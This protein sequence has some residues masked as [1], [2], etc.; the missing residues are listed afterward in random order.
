M[1]AGLALSLRSK[2]QWCDEVL[3]RCGLN[4]DKLAGGRKG[5]YGQQLVMS[6]Y[7]DVVPAVRGRVQAMQGGS[8][9]RSG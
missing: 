4:F 6:I 1:V 3:E 9:G 8:M 5:G 2:G 7:Q